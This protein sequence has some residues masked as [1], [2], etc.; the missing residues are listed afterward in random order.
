MQLFEYKTQEEHVDLIK[1]NY[2]SYNKSL[3]AYICKCSY[4]YAR[5][6]VCMYV[7]TYVRMYV[8]MCAFRYVCMY[9]CVSACVCLCV[10][11]CM[12]VCIDVNYYTYL[13][14]EGKNT[15]S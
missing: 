8:C 15:V 2:M 5:I 9:V 6:H 11:V 3:H 7:C 4:V 12:Y 1:T 13:F 10:S 14:L